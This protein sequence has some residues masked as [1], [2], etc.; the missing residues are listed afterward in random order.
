MLMPLEYLLVKLSAL[1]CAPAGRRTSPVPTPP[2]IRLLLPTVAPALLDMLPPVP[3]PS[4]SGRSRSNG[5]ERNLLR[6]VLNDSTLAPDSRYPPPAPA[7]TAL[8]GGRPPPF[9]AAPPTD[10]PRERR[11]SAT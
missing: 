6:R 9:A 10:C 11:I 5:S 8:L 2:L 4:S 3:L 1:V 7:P